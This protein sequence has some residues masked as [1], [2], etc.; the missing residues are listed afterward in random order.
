MTPAP[1]S[2]YALI[3]RACEA[4]PARA[5]LTLL[6]DDD[7]LAEPR[8]WSYGELLEQVHRTGNALGALGV[9]PRDV[10]AVLLPAGFEY[11]LAHW[12]GQSAGIVMPL[13]PLLREER[14]VDLLDAARAKVLIAYGDDLDVG[15]WHKARHVVAR[16]RHAPRLVRVAPRNGGVPIGSP[17]A[18]DALDFDGLLAAQPA[19][20]LLRRHAPDPSE[21]AAYFHT[22]GTTGSPKVAMLT[23]ANQVHTAL[24]TAQMQQITQADRMLGSGPMYHVAAVLVGAL[25]CLSVGAEVI[26]PSSTL[27]RNPAVVRNYWRL[28]A[29]LKPTILTMVPT[30][31]SSVCDVPRDG[32]DL[33]SIR[34][35]RTGAAPLPHATASRLEREFG[36]RLNETY[37]MT[38]T[39]GASCMVPP[40]MEVPPGCVGL[41]LPGVQLRVARVDPNGQPSAEDAPAGE[42]GM[43]LF[44]GPNVFAGYLDEASTRDA[45][46]AGGW[47]ISGDLGRLDEGGR[48][49]LVGRAKD[50][51]VRSGHNIDPRG[52][53][54]QL[55]AHPAVSECAVVGAPDAYAGE[56]P[57]AFVTLRPG[58]HAS[59]AQLRDFAAARVDEAPAR[60]RRVT[61]LDSLPLTNVGKVYKPAL[62]QRAAVAVVHQ[63]VESCCRSDACLADPG[64][65]PE[66]IAEG[67]VEVTV[68]FA[69]P[70]K[71]SLRRRLELEFARLQLKVHLVGAGDGR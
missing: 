52:V 23:H 51:I 47:L 35:C 29:R 67:E 60:P 33:S 65:P 3:R 9:G 58:L 15:Y 4:W 66:V 13:N 16:C 41:P 27:M 7:P 54:E 11:H 70:L 10:T 1:P 21:V 8:R 5:A 59:E 63:V 26:V 61:V 38:E 53:E 30:L 57:V 62:R 25:T 68:R 46:T 2:T 39:G 55:R 44:Q 42:A 19:D 45:F 34:Y 18:A 14:L 32:A 43:L 69:S 50:I 49:H 40:G 22:G 17:P 20:R 37:G 48:V 64:P 71:A 24:A 36:L 28:V 56:V 12:G 31:W 6:R